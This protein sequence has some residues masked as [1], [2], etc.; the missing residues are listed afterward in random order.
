MCYGSVEFLPCSHVGHIFRPGH[1]YNM[2]GERGKLDV[3]GW[4]TQRLAEV[5]MDEYKRIFYL[6]RPDLKGRDCGDLTSRKEIKKKLNCRNFKWY[7]ENIFPEKFIPDE[8]VTAFG[9]IKNSKIQPGNTQYCL[10]T[11]SKEN[12]VGVYPCQNGGGNQVK[13]LSST[14]Y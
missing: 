13:L 6:I 9:E 4:N 1:P 5:W 14:W 12:V 2:T 11:L 7:L 3:N 10:D 8:K